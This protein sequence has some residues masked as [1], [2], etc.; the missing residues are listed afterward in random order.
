MD[1]TMVGTRA[2]ILQSDIFGCWSEVTLNQ[3][4]RKKER[5]KPSETLIEVE[6]ASRTDWQLSQLTLELLEKPL[7]LD[8]SS[9]A[10]RFFEQGQEEEEGLQLADTPDTDDEKEVELFGDN[11]TKKW[12][13]NDHDIL[14]EALIGWHLSQFK[15]RSNVAGKLEAMEWIYQPDVHHSKRFWNGHGYSVR[16]IYAREI[17]FTF[18]HCC[19]RAGYD[20][21][22]IQLGLE[23]VLKKAGLTELLLHTN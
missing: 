22:L 18:Q 5:T 14:H 9:N 2:P 23:H 19:L 8:Q 7:D 21:E 17:P 10:L 16:H 1:K 20:P 12:R 11:G 4:K 15:S 13:D 3:R 6:I